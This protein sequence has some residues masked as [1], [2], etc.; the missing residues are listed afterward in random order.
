MGYTTYDILIKLKTNLEEQKQVTDFLKEYKFTYWLAELFGEWDLLLEIAAGNIEHFAKMEKDILKN[1]GK[2]IEQ[3]EVHIGLEIYKIVPIA[4]DF[5]D[6]K[7]F[8]LAR[9]RDLPYK[10]DA[11]DKQ[12]LWRQQKVFLQLFH[13]AT[14]GL[15][16][17]NQI[18]EP[19]L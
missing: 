8:S 16:H 15:C 19:L 11:K 17:K 3:Y 13:T 2:H 4:E 5:L 14:N 10:I 18:S 1:I 12:I 9:K 6:G 7:K